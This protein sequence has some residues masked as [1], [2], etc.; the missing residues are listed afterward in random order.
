MRTWVKII[1]GLIV[2]GMITAVLVYVFVVN[3]SHPDYENMKPD[4]ALSASELYNSFKTNTTESG[5]RYN[6]K[7][8]AVTGRLTKVES[9][10]SLVIAVFVLNQGIFG[11]E[12]IRCT[13]LTKFNVQA[14]KLQAG[15]VYRIKGYCTGYND[16]D[17]IVEQCSII[18]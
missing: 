9:N 17:V 8:V 7:L 14:K 15:N 2:L 16:P 10:D 5:T 1:L 3:K 13:M 18:R 6:G 12:G 11:N 4:Y